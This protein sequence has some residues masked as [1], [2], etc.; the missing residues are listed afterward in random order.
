[1]I[2]QAISFSAQASAMIECGD[3]EIF[4]ILSQTS[5]D[6]RRTLLSLQNVVRTHAP[7]YTYLEVGSHLG[8]TLL[9]HLSDPLCRQV[10]SID[11]R[12]ASQ[13]DERGRSFDFP[14]NSTERMIAGLAQHLPMASL[15]KLHTVDGDMA[16]LSAGSIP[17]PADLLFLDAE[18]TNQAVFRDF[19]CMR[20]FAKPDCVIAF[21]DTE[22]IFDA[23]ANIETLLADEGTRCLG[24]MLPGSVFALLFGA[25]VD[26]AGN[27][28]ARISVDKALY[29]AEARRELWR[30]I[31]RNHADAPAPNGGV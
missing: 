6:D 18:H 25:F 27:A 20:R 31:A 15:L 13:P 30:E 4:R 22:L 19:L 1:M 16:E 29:F 17:L 28:L 8:G 11:K 21:H 14:D 2:Q 12:P 24:L 10:C 7:G 23:V 5:V 3:V 9:P 26:L